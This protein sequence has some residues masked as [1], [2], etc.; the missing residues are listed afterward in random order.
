M[1][2]YLKQEEIIDKFFT[3]AVM[4]RRQLHQCPHPAWLEYYATGLVAEKLSAWGYTV[5][6]GKEVVAPEERLLL[7]NEKKHH[8]EYQRALQCGIKE[9]FISPAQGGL[10]GVVGVLKGSEP[11]PCVGF[12]FDIDCN[13]VNEACDSGH[14]PAREGFASQHPGYAHMCGHDA[15]TAMGL[16]LAHY[17][18]ENREVIKGTVKLI[19]QPNEEGLSGAVAMVSAGVAED[20]DYLFSGHVG[21]SLEQVGQIAFNVNNFYALSR[22]EVTYRGRAA[23]AALHP[24]E[25]INA[26]LGACTA[27]TNL[28][29]I[30]RHGAGASRINVGT[31]DAGTAC[32]VIPDRA[33]FQLEVRAVTDEI[34]NYLIKKVHE[35]LNGA[36]V[37]YGLELEVTPGAVSYSGENSAELVTLSS[38][39]AQMLPSVKE[40][41]PAASLN[42]SED[43]TLMMERVQSRGGKALY[44]LFGTPTSG[45]HHNASFDVDETVIANGAKFLAAIHEAVTK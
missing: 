40:V 18:A 39:V 5:S 33:S 21:I 43:I 19:F 27:V 23:H 7:P 26:L 22:F 30:S 37:M 34:N 11:G 41:I 6:L 17:F 24:D 36:A 25:G 32:N 3:E 13:E 4:W 29:A 2:M 42:A 15:H 14:R 38:K 28:Y 16:L 20:V 45:G 1:K 35:V 9:E 44:A 31:M 8:D 12:R 10:T